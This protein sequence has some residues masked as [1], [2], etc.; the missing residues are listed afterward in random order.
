[1]I[2]LAILIFS[3]ATAV[4]AAETAVTTVPQPSWMCSRPAVKSCGKGEE[5]PT[6]QEDS[7]TKDYAL[8]IKCLI[9]WLDEFSGGK[10]DPKAY[11]QERARAQVVLEKLSAW[12]KTVPA[13]K[14]P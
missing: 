6:P 4:H 3:M 9:E 13:K 2:K 14:K 5:C 12:A 11:E 10:A 1:M 7:T 8:E